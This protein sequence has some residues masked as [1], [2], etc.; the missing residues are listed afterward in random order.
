MADRRPVA[1]LQSLLNQF[2]TFL[3]NGHVGASRSGLITTFNI[4]LHLQ[5]QGHD[6]GEAFL[7]GQPDKGLALVV[8]RVD[9]DGL[10]RSASHQDEVA[11]TVLLL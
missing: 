7:A 9:V 10:D 3:V 2:S 4:S 11:G 5:A 1:G 8:G 6:S